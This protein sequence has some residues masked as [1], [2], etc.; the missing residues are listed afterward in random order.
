MSQYSRIYGQCEW[1]IW[2]PTLASTCQTGSCLI[3]AAKPF[4]DMHPAL[5]NSILLTSSSKIPP[6]SLKIEDFLF[7]EKYSP[8]SLIAILT[9]HEY[10][11]NQSTFKLCLS[12]QKWVNQELYAKTD[13]LYQTVF[14]SFDFITTINICQCFLFPRLFVFYTTIIHTSWSQ[15]STKHAPKT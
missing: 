4:A 9:E 15:F 1:G 5:Y 10:W 3:N 6:F 8:T 11:Q 14:I 7:L 12:K 13:Y 2:H